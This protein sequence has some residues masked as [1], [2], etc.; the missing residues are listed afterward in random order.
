[1]HCSDGKQLVLVICR[2]LCTCSMMDEEDKLR[3]KQDALG[4]MKDHEAIAR[5]A[6][7]AQSTEGAVS[8]SGCNS[9]T[10]CHNE[11]NLLADV[12]SSSLCAWMHPLELLLVQEV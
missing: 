10:R 1:M 12:G 6:R 8:G 11:Y 9:S 2:C 4:F 7:T 3:A 5:I